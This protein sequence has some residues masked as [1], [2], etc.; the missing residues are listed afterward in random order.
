MKFREVLIRVL[1]S[2][3][4]VFCLYLLVSYASG[5]GDEDMEELPTSDTETK[6]AFFARV[7]YLHHLLKPHEYFAEIKVHPG[8]GKFPLITGGYTETNVHCVIRVR[9]ISVPD[10]CQT[11]DKR[12]RPHEDVERE[13][14]R[15]DA[16]MRYVWNVIEPNRT[17][18]VGNPEIVGDVVEVDVYFS[19]GGAWH[20]LAVSMEADSHAYPITEGYVFDWGKR[21]VEARMEE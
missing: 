15:W 9:G 3:A 12:D 11:E 14:Q 20:D 18:R 5:P 1:G 13:Q 16:A 6:G 19:L 17:L 21:L 10:A 2:V 4:V 7:E 8:T